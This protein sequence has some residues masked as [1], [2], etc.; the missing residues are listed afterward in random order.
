MSSPDHPKPMVFDG[1]LER[2]P[3]SSFEDGLPLHPLTDLSGAWEG[4]FWAGLVQICEVHTY[5]PL[6]AL[7][8]HHHSIG[9]PLRVKQLLNSP[10][11]LKLDHLS[12]TA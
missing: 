12:L 3:R 2:H 10:G 1:T 5:S 9:Q 4:V 6:P 7:L 8:L 11:Q